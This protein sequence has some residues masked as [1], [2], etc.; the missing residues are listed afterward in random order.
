MSSGSKRIAAILPREMEWGGRLLKGAMDYA[1]R[2]RAVQFLDIP[3]SASAPAQLRLGR[4]LP[5]DAALIW[6]NREAQ[7]VERLIAD[8][9]PMVSA[10]GDWPCD[11]VP[12]LVFDNAQVVRAAVDHL[13]RLRGAMLL[14]VEFILDGFPL[15]EARAGLFREEAARHGL[16]ARSRGLFP[17]GKLP[18]DILDY[19]RPL[20]ADVAKRLKRWLRELPKP[21][22][23]WCGDDT[24]AMR[25]CEAAEQLGLQV[26]ADVAVLGLGNFRMSELSNPP[27]SSI[28]LP[29]EV[30][31]YRAFEAL[32]RQ[33]RG[34]VD[35]PSRILLAPPEIIAREST[36]GGVEDSILGRAVRL[37]SEHACN[38]ITVREVAGAVSLSPQALHTRF[39]KGIGRPPGEEIRRVRLAA[40]KRFLQDPRL[41]V[42]R[43]SALCGF[44][45]QSKFSKFFRRETGEGERELAEN[46][47]PVDKRTQRNVCL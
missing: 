6:A 47:K 3:Y 30:L 40:A 13:R 38:G 41:S 2:H 32:H 4:S 18:E 11:R 19:Q 17:A 33:L 42:A 20:A 16:P 36:T 34:E 1:R 26:P 22:G 23:V 21:L 25:V 7:W 46:C 9:L 45:Q 43:V 8:G 5:F 28:P 39:L 27:L 44:G 12:N 35:L 10:S 37:I 15:H 29:G 14:H 31:G 24:L